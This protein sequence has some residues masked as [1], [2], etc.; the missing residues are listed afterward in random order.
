MDKA[1]V[2]VA[3]N[4]V[5]VD[6]NKADISAHANELERLEDVK[7]DKKDFVDISDRVDVATNKNAEQDVLIA[8]KADVDYVNSYY[9]GMAAQAEKKTN[10]RLEQVAANQTKI[11]DAQD[12][13]ISKNEEII[14]N[15]GYKIGDLEDQLSAGIASTVALA[16]MPSAMNAGETRVA[17]GTG[18][19]NGHSAIALGMTGSTST[20]D[21]YKIG[22]SYTKS[23]GVVVG[24][25]VSFLVK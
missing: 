17:G 5:G 24:G 23:G 7:M 9:S 1:N 8:A 11:D 20:G 25:G 22:S 3:D 2:N 19:Y 13:R 15:F 6:K 18:Y 16:F 10:E 14:N 21:F 12:V 4:K